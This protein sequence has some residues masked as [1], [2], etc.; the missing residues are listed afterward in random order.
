LEV[1][2][3]AKI[4]FL[5]HETEDCE[6]ILEKLN[7]VLSLSSESFAVTVVRGHHRNL[8]R[9]WQATLEG[10]ELRRFLKALLKSYEGREDLL[11]EIPAHMD[12]SGN[13]YLRI[14][15]DSLFEGKVRLSEKNPVRIELALSRRLRPPD[16]IE[17]YRSFFSS[18]PQE[19]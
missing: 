17:A 7:E 18:A 8:I 10:E 5:T 13:F 3:K 15:K 6:K 4:S 2:S 12:E 11:R 1:I 16:R 19:D 9:V 14:D